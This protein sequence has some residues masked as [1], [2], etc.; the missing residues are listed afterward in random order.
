I[1]GKEEVPS[2]AAGVPAE[3][4]A[5]VSPARPEDLKQGKKEEKA[6]D[7]KETGAPSKKR[8]LGIGLATAGREHNGIDHNMCHNDLDHMDKQFGV[9]I[10]QECEPEN[11]SD[12]IVI[13]E[14]TAFRVKPQTFMNKSGLVLAKVFERY[15]AAIPDVIAVY[16][17]L[18][19]PLGKVRVRQKGS[20]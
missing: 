8:C 13:G 15:D 17:E 10:R 6:P 7:E 19:L 20:A 12:R 16:D 3:S 9:R 5:A 2:P 4:E 14:Q 11:V 1:A 18:A